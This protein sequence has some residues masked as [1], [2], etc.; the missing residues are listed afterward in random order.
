MPQWFAHQS[1]SLLR[2]VALVV[3]KP[4]NLELFCLLFFSSHTSYLSRYY[5]YNTSFYYFCLSGLLEAA[6][7]QVKKKKK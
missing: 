7:T 6:P 2:V 5:P 3:R 4:L 1:Y